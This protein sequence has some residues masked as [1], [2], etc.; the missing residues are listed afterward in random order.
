ME[1]G[2]PNLGSVHCQH[3]PPT[4]AGAGLHHKASLQTP[5]RGTRAEIS[6]CSYQGAVSLLRWLQ[7]RY[8]SASKATR[9]QG[10]HVLCQKLLLSERGEWET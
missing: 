4:A 9:Q 6:P 3:V 8:P 1:P 10:G 2:P 7:M 5:F